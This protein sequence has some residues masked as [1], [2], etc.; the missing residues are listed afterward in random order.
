MP[1]DQNDSI[2]TLIPNSNTDQTNKLQ[3]DQPQPGQTKPLPSGGAAGIWPEET[4]IG[5]T[6]F[7]REII[8]A[9]PE[10]ALSENQAET[11]PKQEKAPSV[12]KKSKKDTDTPNIMTETLENISKVK[13][14]VV[15]KTKEP[16][17]LHRVSTIADS[18][19]KTADEEEE[20]FIKEVIKEHQT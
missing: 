15:N 7:I 19:T 5:E 9:N 8:P 1:T 16:E 4:P 11:V 17:K 12:E 20:D 3:P 10:T 6:G 13:T 14:N 2:N 18:L